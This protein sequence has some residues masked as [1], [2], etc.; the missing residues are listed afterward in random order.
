MEINNMKK[1]TEQFAQ[2]LKTIHNLTLTSEY[3][4]AHSQVTFN[5]PNGHQNQAT[6]TNVLK[7]GYKCKQCA[8]GL[9]YVPDRITWDDHNILKLQAY[10]DSGLS[11]DEIAALFNTTKSA[12]HN[13]TNKFGIVRTRT[14]ENLSRLQEV[15]QYQNREL[16][17][18][19]T[20][21]HAN[22]TVRC[23][24]NHTVRQ[25]AGNVLYKN[26]GCPD[27]FNTQPSGEQIE[28]LN[29]IKSNYDG[30]I[31]EGD[32]KILGGRELDIVLPDLG[33][34]FEYNG[35]YW[36]SDQRVDKY[37]HQQKSDLT[38]SFGYQLI[39]INS[40]IYN[41]KKD[42]VHS[43][44]LH[45]IK[46]QRSTGARHT[47]SNT[48]D[49]TTC[50][51]FLNRYHIQGAGAPTNLNYGLYI[52][53][54]LVAVATFGKPRWDNTHELELVRYATSTPITGG[55][56]KLLGYHKNSSIITYAN[57]DWSVGKLYQYNGFSKVG[58]TQPNYCW[59][60]RYRERLTRYQSQKHLLPQV[61]GNRFDPSISES[62]NL[63]ACGWYRVWD[64]GNLVYSRS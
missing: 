53:D 18:E 5:C 20:G 14:N 24:N 29:F 28:L 34:A 30:W 62:E 25:L 60:N 64:S 54:N 15:L 43:K 27:C 4:G 13:A 57:R 23:A 61:L 40:W 26:T 52:R 50:K 10:L 33:L 1:T 56:G 8:Q 42:L 17:S 31:V 37:Y 32:R 36:H 11:T 49:W 6:A 3:A 48:I 38:E 7:R 2:E 21:S 9:S 58:I 51:D 44:I 45:L 46:P 47:T 19:F 12:I 55:L 59:Y 41:H 39:H 35:V 63:N 16:V 22:I